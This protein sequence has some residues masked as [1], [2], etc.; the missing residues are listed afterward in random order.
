MVME[1]MNTETSTALVQNDVH[2]PDYIKNKGRK[3]RFLISTLPGFDHVMIV[4]AKSYLTM[5]KR[6]NN[7]DYI[8]AT[9][10]N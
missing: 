1:D 3:F 6:L 4:M 10:F 5:I 7:K 9:L 2:D 8:C